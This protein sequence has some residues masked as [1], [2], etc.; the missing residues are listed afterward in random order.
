M[1]GQF[2]QVIAQAQAALSVRGWARFLLWLGS[3]ALVAGLLLALLY[4][5]RFHH[6]WAWLTIPWM[7]ATHG[8]LNSVGFVLLSFLGFTLSRLREPLGYGSFPR[9]MPMA[10]EA[11]AQDRSDVRDFF[12]S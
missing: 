3:G 11:R 4:G 12:S 5:W 10:K 6:Q 7:Y 8:V 2:T 9:E 1:F